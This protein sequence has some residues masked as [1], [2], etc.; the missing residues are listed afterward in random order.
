M[1]RFFRFPAAIAAVLC[2]GMLVDGDPALGEDG[3]SAGSGFQREFSV[4]RARGNRFEVSA[5]DG[6]PSA[7]DAELSAA[8]ISGVYGFVARRVA[9]RADAADIAQQ[10]LL[11]ACAKRGTW[12][13]ANLSAWLFAIARHLIVD[14]YRAKNRFQ[15]VEVTALAETNS[16]LQTPLDTPAIYEH[17]ERL[18]DWLDCVTRRLHLEEQAAVLLADVHAYRDKDSAAV[19]R[20]SVPSFKLLLHGARARLHEIAGG[21]SM[22]G[23]NT[24]ATVCD[25]S[26]NGYGG[27]SAAPGNGRP[28]SVYPTYRTGVTCHLGAP[29]LLALRDR[30]LEGLSL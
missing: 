15:F 5:A 3:D 29:Q 20:M 17:R 21:N 28:P 7:A 13:G 10:T 8:D 6:E 4:R 14:H 22:L 27:K 26:A 30:L 25:D 9:N 2:A 24:T 16:A 12:R 1:K 11:L 19:L 18:T 23:R